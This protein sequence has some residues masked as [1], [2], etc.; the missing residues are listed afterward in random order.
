MSTVLHQFL[1]GGL[2]PKIMSG[3]ACLFYEDIGTGPAV[4]LSHSWQ[5]DGRQWPQ[6]PALVAAGYRVLNLDGRGHGRSGPH[7][8]RFTMWDMAEDLIAVL[9][10]ADVD[11]AVLVGL[12]VGGFAAIRA[13]LRHQPRVRALALAD[14]G[15]AP[16]ARLGRAKVAALGRL[17]LTPARRLT[18]DVVVKQLFGPTARRHQPELVAQWRRRFLDQDPASMLVAIQSI[19]ARDDVTSR[20]AEISAP[21]LVIVGEEDRDPGVM[22]SVSLAARIPGARLTVLPDTGHL[23]ALEQPDAFESALLGFLADL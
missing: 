22:A 1:N 6:V 13:A 17:S 3:S 9:D 2:M 4:L 23:A 16:A 7:R 14:T 15:A 12:S 11:D 20:L 10:D 18:V 21:T 8:Q 19:M 5:C